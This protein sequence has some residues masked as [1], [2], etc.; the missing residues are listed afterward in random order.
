MCTDPRPV[1]CKDVEAPKIEAS[2]VRKARSHSLAASWVEQ[3]G[4]RGSGR[5]VYAVDARSGTVPLSLAEHGRA[6]L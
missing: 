6:K 3:R 2:G 4:R 1:S 5:P